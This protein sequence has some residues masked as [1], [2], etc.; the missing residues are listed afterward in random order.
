MPIR[1][2]LLLALALVVFAAIALSLI[3]FHR[4]GR[5]GSPAGATGT[6]PATPKVTNPLVAYVRTE[7]GMYVRP[8][9]GGTAVPIATAAGSTAI[10]PNGRRIAYIARDENY[11]GSEG[12]YDAAY[13]VP[14]GGL[15]PQMV[16]VDN[17]FASDS[18]PAWSRD[19]ST[20]AFIVH[21]D[22]SEEVV[23]WDGTSINS[24]YGSETGS[25]I[26]GPPVLSPAKDAVAFGNSSSLRIAR[27]DRMLDSQPIVEEKSGQVSL[28]A[29]AWVG[30][31]LFVA[32]LCAYPYDR[33]QKPDAVYSVPIADSAGLQESTAG[34][35][36]IEKL[37]RRLLTL[38]KGTTDVFYSPSSG[39]LMYLGPIPIGR[40]RA[41]RRALS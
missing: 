15:N 20:L 23:L 18:T 9:H 37:G 12:Q 24:V 22:G 25:S 13:V 41:S 10:S 29:L 35:V 34:P 32:E 40:E 3:I 2:L 7:G 8:L 19:G 17:Y 21:N 27:I 4:P 28:Y 1:R 39:Y 33:C 11:S 38:P 5:E 31:T 30:R 6:A 36:S 16:E 26:D 14:N